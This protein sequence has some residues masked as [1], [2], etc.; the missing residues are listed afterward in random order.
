VHLFLNSMSAWDRPSVKILM[1]RGGGWDLH[2]DSITPG[3]PATA[4]ASNASNASW[5]I[6]RLAPAGAARVEN[7]RRPAGTG[8]STGRL[9]VDAYSSH[10][11]ERHLQGR[12]NIG[13]QVR[14]YL[15]QYLLATHHRF[16]SAS[17]NY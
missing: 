13:R 5:T 9:G 8:S 6:G 3:R 12:A 10:G 1:M 16:L 17:C 15:Q 14:Q 4:A 2:L 7:E 11:F